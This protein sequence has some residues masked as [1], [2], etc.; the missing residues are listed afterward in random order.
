MIRRISG[1]S[2]VYT[3]SHA[4]FEGVEFYAARWYVHLTK[5]R[6]E[7][8]FFVREEEEEDDEALTVSELLLFVEQRVCGVETSDLPC[9]DS[10]RN[11]NFTSDDMADVRHQGVAVDD[12][13]NP[14]P[15]NI[16]LPQLE[17]GYSWRSEEII[18][19]RRS[20]NLPN[21]YAAFKN[22]SHEEVM[23][24]TKLELFLILFTAGGVF[25]FIFCWVSKRDTLPQNE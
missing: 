24:M 22:Y 9:L 19:P 21:T 7:E 16:P 12:D 11:S 13:N 14:A 2:S 25:N 4:D 5:E 20:N 6:R 17:D 1:V 3:F 23:K 18:C 15:Q 10:G 8:D